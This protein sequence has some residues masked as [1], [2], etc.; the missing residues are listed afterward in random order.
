MK[1]KI[2]SILF[3]FLLT[4]ISILSIILNDKEVSKTERRKLKQFPTLN[5]NTVLNGDFFDNLEEYHLDQIVFR[6]NLKQLKSNWDRTIFKIF[7]QDGMIINNNNLFKINY[8][9]NE[10]N[11][12]SFSKKINR[13]SSDYIDSNIYFS[14]IPD[15]NY[16]LDNNFLKMDYDAFIKLLNNN[17]NMEYIDLTNSF[18]ISSYYLT[19]IHIRQEKWVNVI[20]ILEEKYNFTINDE[21]EKVEV[22]N[23]YGS[24]SNRLGL[25]EISDTLNYHTSIYTQNTKVTHLDYPNTNTV[26]DTSKLNKI[27]FYDVYLSGASSYIVLDNSLI[28][29]NKELIIFRDSFASSL[30][31]L[32]LG[33]YEKITL[34]DL[35]YIDYDIVKQYLNYKN[36]DVLFLYSIDL[37]NNSGSIKVKT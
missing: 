35:R 9:I 27:D 7:D 2:F 25:F 16:Y 1:E 36:K 30:T 31:P 3:V 23:F 12:L 17:L 8:K 21:F 29:N 19:D 18:D 6:N 13:I 37:I 5:I 24:L 26:Y 28:K 11:V 10:K 33:A 14:M 4:L 15:K 20:K 22:P 34:V 32:L